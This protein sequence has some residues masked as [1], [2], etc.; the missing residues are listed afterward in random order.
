MAIRR[1]KEGY[2]ATYG[3]TSRTYKKKADAQKFADKYKAAKTN[4]RSGT[5]SNVSKRKRAKLTKKTPRT[6]Y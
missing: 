6:G 4:T 2:V 1:T 5:K 3:G